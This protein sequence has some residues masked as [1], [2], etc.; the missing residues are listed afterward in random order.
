[1]S[2]VR[3]VVLTAITGL[4]VF[5]LA[6]PAEAQVD[7]YSLPIAS[8]GPVVLPP[9]PA[10]LPP[11]L[12]AQQELARQVGFAQFTAPNWHVGPVRRIVL[13]KYK[14][15]VSEAQKSELTARFLR[16]VHDSHRAD[17][18]FVIDSIEASVPQGGAGFDQVFTL[19]FRSEGDRNFFAGAP[20]VTDTAFA[21]PARVA[22]AAF[23]EPLTRHL[24]VLNYDVAVT[25]KSAVAVAP[26]KR[27]HDRA[28]R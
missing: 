5:G 10:R 12:V 13:I 14:N 15:G 2:V 11:E 24:I 9:L 22:F 27:K 23:A 19:T 8:S 25:V 4:V 18:R 17:G 7:P 1:M 26:H 3:S 16:L 21:D 28:L 6:Q 20:I